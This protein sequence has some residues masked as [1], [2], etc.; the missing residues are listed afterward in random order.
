LLVHVSN[1]TWLYHLRYMEKEL[2]DR[3]NRSARGI[4]VNALKFKIGPS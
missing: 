4:R 3:L 2:I 1:S